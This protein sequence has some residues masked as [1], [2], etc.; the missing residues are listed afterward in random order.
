LL[1]VFVSDFYLTGFPVVEILVLVI[2]AEHVN[3]LALKTLP[4]LFQVFRLHSVF[5]RHMSIPA[6]TE[7]TEILLIH[8]I[9]GSFTRCK[10]TAQ[11]SSDTSTGTSNYAANNLTNIVNYTVSITR[12]MPRQ[13]I[14]SR[15]S[16]SVRRRT[17]KVNKSTP[18]SLLP[19]RCLTLHTHTL[20]KK[21]RNRG[22]TVLRISQNIKC[23]LGTVGS[24]QHP[25]PLHWREDA[26]KINGLVTLKHYS[27]LLI[28]YV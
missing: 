25:S 11:T 13:S 14:V 21:G 16:Y 3:L 28:G 19:L 23:C 17:K 27:S 15:I 5:G 6:H 8:W 22:V 26:T 1:N 2:V 10:S 4:N 12:L 24:I 18:K 20:R 9:G 7:I